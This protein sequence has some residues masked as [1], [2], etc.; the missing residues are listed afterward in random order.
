V[1]KT[2]AGDLLLEG[3]DTLSPAVEQ[4]TKLVRSTGKGAFE[5]GQKLMRREA[6]SAEHTE[7]F[8]K[9]GACL[10]HGVDHT[11]VEDKHTHELQ[12]DTKHVFVRN[13]HHQ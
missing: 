1:A 6:W 11:T 5:R 8:I 12:D 9:L 3:I 4:A 2:I 7:A 13:G 10:K